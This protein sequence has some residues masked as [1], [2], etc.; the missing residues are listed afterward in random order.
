MNSITR[1]IK[2][3]PFLGVRCGTEVTK[4]IR[5]DRFCYKKTLR[6]EVLFEMN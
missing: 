2:C 1:C 3:E 4:I 5:P 6:P